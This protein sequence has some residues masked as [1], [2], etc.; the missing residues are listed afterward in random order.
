MERTGEV[1]DEI[2]E[3]ACYGST[4]F[5]REVLKMVS[6]IPFGQT[7]SYK[8][9]AKKIGRPMAAR[10]VGQ[11]LKKNPLPFVIPCHRVVRTDGKI[12]GYRLGKALK[13][14]LLNY[15]KAQIDSR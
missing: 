5:E 9:M 6:Q 15:E 3:R 11:A 12:G 1:R 10:A 2:I 13:Q 14:K 7:R 8:W 4:L